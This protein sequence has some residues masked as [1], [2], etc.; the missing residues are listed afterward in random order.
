[1]GPR[2]E[3]YEAYQKGESLDDNP[4]DDGGSFFSNR[5]QWE[6]G[7]YDAESED[8]TKDDET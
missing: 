7:W 5:N 1:M 3:G 2:Q 4:Y 8:E 6:E